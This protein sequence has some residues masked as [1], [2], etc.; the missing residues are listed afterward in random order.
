[1][2]VRL[3][4]HLQ[5][6]THCLIKD[7]GVRLNY[8]LRL[9]YCSCNLTFLTWIQWVCFVTLVSCMNQL[10]VVQERYETIRTWQSI[11]FNCN[12]FKISALILL[13]FVVS[14][15]VSFKL[16]TIHSKTR[17]PSIVMRQFSFP[18]IG[19]FRFSCWEYI[20]LYTTH[21]W[22]KR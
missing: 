19:M 17:Q 7:I 8:G 21:F 3:G 2:V 18:H 1:M 22:E 16:V 4:S 10:Q 11:C 5:H 13:G 12:T 20:N 9:V 14:Y 6:L 15:Y